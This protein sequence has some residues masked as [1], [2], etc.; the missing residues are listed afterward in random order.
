MRKI[1]VFIFALCWV[2][3]LFGQDIQLSNYRPAGMLFNPSLAGTSGS[4]VQIGFMHRNQWA[5]IRR[6]PYTTTAALA[7]LRQNKIGLGFQV[8]SQKAGEAS[9]K[10]T[11]VM[12]T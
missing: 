8:F 5:A 4:D 12:F 10:T 2:V 3:S 11:G 1:T 6:Q 7:E 9:L